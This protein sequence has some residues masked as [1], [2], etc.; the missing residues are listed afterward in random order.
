M[1]SVTIAALT[2]LLSTG[3]L[4]V[5]TP[6]H[7]HGHG[8][9]HAG[10]HA[11]MHLNRRDIVWITEFEVETVTVMKTVYGDGSEPTDAPDTLSA[12]ETPAP[13]TFTSYA[14][15]TT[16]QAPAPVTTS[17]TP[18][19][20]TS[21]SSSSTTTTTTSTTTQAPAPAPVT[22]QSSSYVAPAPA[23]QT[24]SSASAS[25]YQAPAPPAP[26]SSAPASPPS[27]GGGACTASSDESATTSG[28]CHSGDFTWYDVGMG[29]CGITNVET[30]AIVAIAKDLF[31][32][33]TPGGN[34][35]ANTL[36][37]RKVN[38]YNKDGTSFS[39]TVTDRCVGCATTDLDLSK[40][41]FN[42]VT[43]NG[44]GRVHGMAWDWA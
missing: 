5:P 34:P 40:S 6:G 12:A 42:T 38:L 29:A 41:L 28:S 8:H 32:K 18:A 1:K 24:T 3:A 17:A 11:D 37:G 21:S 10:R 36:C 16:S 35:N 7:V 31:D 20:Y 14:A 25:T 15:K 19:A 23:P 30:D 44:D 43:N 27:Y 39:A 33:Y 9:R 2:A 13:V 4:A 26:S 22:T